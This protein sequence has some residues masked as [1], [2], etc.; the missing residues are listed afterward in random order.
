MPAI[1]VIIVWLFALRG[2]INLL[3]QILSSTLLYTS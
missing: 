1:I 2:F 3:I